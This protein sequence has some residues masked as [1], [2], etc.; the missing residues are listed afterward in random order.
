MKITRSEKY[1]DL[2][3]DIRKDIKVHE[4]CLSTGSKNALRLEKSIARHMERN[5]YKRK[6][7][8]ND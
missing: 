3:D 6:H 1:K 4:Y 7:A 2:L 8:K 5:P